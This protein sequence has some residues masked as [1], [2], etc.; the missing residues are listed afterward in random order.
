MEEEDWIFCDN[1]NGW[2]HRGCIG[3]EDEAVWTKYSPEAIE[4]AC[5][6]CE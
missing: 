6:M 5:P 4:Y 1:C 3:L 2:Y